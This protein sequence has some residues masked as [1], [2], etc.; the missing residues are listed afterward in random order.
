MK[1]LV[2]TT[3]VLLAACMPHGRT[4]LPSQRVHKP[5]AKYLAGCYLGR[6]G[7]RMLLRSDLTVK[8]LF[9]DGTVRD[10][11]SWFVE[12]SHVLFGDREEIKFWGYEVYLVP[13]TGYVLTEVNDVMHQVAPKVCGL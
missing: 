7:D 13:G 4:L 5:Q 8:N 9:R 12:N 3:F 11:E 10:G 2:V 1:A 6:A